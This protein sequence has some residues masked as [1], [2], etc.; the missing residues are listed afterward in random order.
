MLVANGPQQFD[1]CGPFFPR[2]APRRATGG[3]YCDRSLAAVIP[4]AI[5]PVAVPTIVAVP[6]VV[7]VPPVVTVA[8]V[9]VSQTHDDTPAQQG[10]KE[11]KEENAFHAFSSVDNN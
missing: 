6:V 4:V 2:R 1:C 10:A 11:R 5:P 8:S 7:T 9:T 3:A